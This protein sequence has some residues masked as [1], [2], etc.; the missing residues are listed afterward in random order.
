MNWSLKDAKNRLTEI[1]NPALTQGPQRVNRGGDSVVVISWDE[2]VRM[3][4]EK[5]S[6]K[7]LLMDGPDFEGLDL[8]RSQTP[9]R[10]VE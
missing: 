5:P 2:Y 7:S 6:F 9:M 1:V 4:G 10:E 8:E 3:T